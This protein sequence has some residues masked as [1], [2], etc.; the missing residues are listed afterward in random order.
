MI[1]MVSLVLINQ[2]Y[3]DLL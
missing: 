1:V 3:R 2:N